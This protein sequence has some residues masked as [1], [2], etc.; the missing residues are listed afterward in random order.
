[1]K[2]KHKKKPQD[3]IEIAKERIK[4]LF[5]QAEDAEQKYSDRYVEIARKISMKIKVKFTPTQKKKFCKHCF[6]YLRPGV[7]CRVR[8]RDGKLIYTCENCKGIM[9]FPGLKKN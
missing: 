8:T 3:Q 7:N 1:M 9:R 5:K 4:E 2:R 6:T